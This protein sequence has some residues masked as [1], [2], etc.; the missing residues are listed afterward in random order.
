MKRR[1]PLLFAVYDLTE[2]MMYSNFEKKKKKTFLTDFRALDMS[3]KVY[4][5]ENLDTIRRCNE[6]VSAK[7]ITTMK[8]RDQGCWNTKMLVDKLVS[9][10]EPLQFSHPKQY[11]NILLFVELKVQFDFCQFLTSR[12]HLMGKLTFL[13]KWIIPANQKNLTESSWWQL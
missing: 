5:S 7:N 13:L 2:N 6:K 12:L 11:K 8:S 3:L 1:I 4:I 10:M 9:T